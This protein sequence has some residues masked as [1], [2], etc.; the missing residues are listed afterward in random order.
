MVFSFCVFPNIKL[1][2]TVIKFSICF[3]SETGV[4]VFSLQGLKITFFNLSSKFSVHVV[5]LVQKRYT[6]L[7]K[8]TKK[9]N[10]TKLIFG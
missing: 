8:K 4:C 3:L 6:N 2:A 5:S 7:A 10:E 9:E 1:C